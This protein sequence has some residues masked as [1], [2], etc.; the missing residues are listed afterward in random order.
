MRS[1]LLAVLAAAAFYA[2]ACGGGEQPSPTF[3]PV[4]AETAATPIVTPGPSPTSIAF[5]I[6]A[7]L[8]QP[9]DL[10]EDWQFQGVDEC[11]GNG[12]RAS[13]CPGQGV[14]GGKVAFA[15]RGP[16]EN[17]SV[18]VVLAEPGQAEAVAQSIVARALSG[19]RPWNRQDVDQPVPGTVRLDQELSDMSP[20]RVV[21]RIIFYQGPVV[22]DISLN[23]DQT[24]Q[25][26]SIDQLAF[27]IQERIASHLP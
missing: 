16:A 15:T 26:P 3:T 21:H 6:D 11:G 18:V 8:L 5:H 22:A 27:L 4:P 10:P 7:A 19:E 23:I 24:S 17:L 12:P 9:N 14:V 20:P 13:L 2:T 25:D 1:A